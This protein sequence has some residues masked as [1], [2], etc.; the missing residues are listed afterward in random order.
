MPAEKP[1]LLLPWIAVLAIAD[2]AWFPSE[3]VRWSWIGLDVVSF[4]ALQVLSRQWRPGLA[5]TLAG[6]AV[7]DLVLGV[8][9]ALAHN[10][11]GQ[12]AWWHLP[13]ITLALLA[14]AFAAALLW[15]AR[16]RRSLPPPAAWC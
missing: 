5:M 2:E 4:V 16:H 12:P 7:L 10:L 9:Q 6:F 11:P 15:T 1:L 8:T 3:A 14:P 13:I